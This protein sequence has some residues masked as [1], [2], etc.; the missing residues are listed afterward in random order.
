MD[1]IFHARIHFSMYLFL[2]LLTA[3]TCLSFWHHMGVCAAI[4]LVLFPPMTVPSGSRLGR[5]FLRIPMS[6]VVPPMSMTTASLTPAM[7]MA[8]IRLAAGPERIVSTGLS[9]AK[10]SFIIVPSPREIMSG[11]D[12]PLSSRTARTERMSSSMTGISLL[13]K[14]GG[15]LEPA[16]RRDV[17]DLP[18]HL[19]DPDLVLRIPDAHEAGDRYSLDLT[20]DRLEELPGLLL[21]EVLY[22]FTV[23]PMAALDPDA[24]VRGQR[25]VVVASD[26]DQPYTAAPPLDDRVCGQSG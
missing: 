12:M 10:E 18:G 16:D 3:G 8:P 2:V 13:F 20:L 4:T 15:Q 23:D 26:A 14:V 24:V 7:D 19:P 1:K 25:V 6:V 21:A 11:A 17:Q 22:R 9:L 5:P